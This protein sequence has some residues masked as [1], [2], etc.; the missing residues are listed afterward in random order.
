MANF[1]MVSEWVCG[2][3]GDDGWWSWW[4]W[5][6]VLQLT[7]KL[8]SSEPDVMAAKRAPWG[9]RKFKCTRGLV[10]DLCVD[11][12]VIRA[13]A[14]VHQVARGAKTP[15]P[16]DHSASV[17]SRGCKAKV[18]QDLLLQILSLHAAQSATRPDELQ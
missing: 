9:K 1:A 8:S 14:K 6:V 17:P 11:G 12:V 15:K 4:W 3:S 5:V 10:I 18:H 2:R 7:S 13:H 16:S